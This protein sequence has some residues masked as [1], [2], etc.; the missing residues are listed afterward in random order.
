MR[1]VIVKAVFITSVIPSYLFGENFVFC[2][3]L[4]L[5]ESFGLPKLCQIQFLLWGQP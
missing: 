1:R 4:A 2:L 3:V 5:S